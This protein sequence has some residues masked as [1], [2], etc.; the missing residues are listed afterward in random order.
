[1]HFKPIP[2]HPVIRLMIVGA[3][4]LALTALALTLLGAVAPPVQA[5]KEGTAARLNAAIPP[6]TK[7]LRS[8]AGLPP[9]V[10]TT[11]TTVSGVSVTVAGTSTGTTSTSGVTSTSIPVTGIVR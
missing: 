11:T 2:H 10:T 9:L 8:T 1:M 6:I 4:S 7:S 3:G 5:D